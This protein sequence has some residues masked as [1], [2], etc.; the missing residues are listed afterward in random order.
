MVVAGSDEA[1][2][3]KVEK[4]VD[5][6]HLRGRNKINIHFNRTVARSS[7]KN[8]S[9]EDKETLKREGVAKGLSEG[10][11]STVTA[12]HE[13]CKK[14]VSAGRKAFVYYLH[15]KGACCTRSRE[16]TL[17]ITTWRDAMN[18]FSLEFP[19]IC[20]RALLAGYSACGMELQDGHFS[21]NY[22]WG[23]CDHIAAL[24]SLWDRFDAYAVEYFIFNV[25]K[26][27]HYNQA[28]SNRCGYSVHNF[29]VNHYATPCWRP[30]YIPKLFSYLLSDDVPDQSIE[31]EQ[32]RGRKEEEGMSQHDKLKT[33]DYARERGNGV[34]SGAKQWSKNTGPFFAKEKE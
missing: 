10:E 11:V 7:T 19:S 21:G 1:D 17:A 2:K 13:Y 18:A 25:S 27:H 30:S 8:L 24:P 28:F 29:H 16:K 3:R 32:E 14:E 6:L 33:C 22:F 23:S 9:P 34:Y 5:D 26:H 12:M 15:S 31:K 20:L 4:L